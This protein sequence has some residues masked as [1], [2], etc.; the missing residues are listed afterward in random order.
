MTRLASFDTVTLPNWLMKQGVAA[1]FFENAMEHL[2][3]MA[4]FINDNRHLVKDD[5]LFYEGGTEKPRTSVDVAKEAKKLRLRNSRLY[6]TTLGVAES[7]PSS[8]ILQVIPLIL[9]SWTCNNRRHR[10]HHPR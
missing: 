4:S 3:W 6:A 2:H 10:R 9:S 7:C 8:A 1:F 5:E